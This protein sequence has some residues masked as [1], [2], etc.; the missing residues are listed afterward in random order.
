MNEKEAR[1]AYL[2]RDTSN[3]NLLEIKQL[4]DELAN[5]RQDYEDNLIDQQLERLSKQMMM[6]K[7]HEKT[8]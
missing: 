2:R 1:L 6:P 3:A 5:S 8:N 7:R 4:E